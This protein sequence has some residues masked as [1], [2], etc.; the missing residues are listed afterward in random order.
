MSMPRPTTC[1]ENE[2]IR[3]EPS[4]RRQSGGPLLSVR[5]AQTNYGWLGPERRQHLRKFRITPS[6]SYTCIVNECGR[7]GPSDRQQSAGAPLI[8]VCCTAAHYDSLGCQLPQKLQK[9]RNT[10][11]PPS[12]T[13][14]GTANECCRMGSSVRQQAAGAPLLSTR[15]VQTT[16]GSSGSKRHQHLRSFRS[17]PSQTIADSANECDWLGPSAMQQ[18]AGAPRALYPC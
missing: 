1:G 6:R 18:F 15:C 14:K 4:V 12:H 8:T 3:L 9:T 13:V 17:T 5:Y 16:Y 11:C 10:R 7:L 2:C